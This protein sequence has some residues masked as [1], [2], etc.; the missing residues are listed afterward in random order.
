MT[1]PS[2]A[3]GAPVRE[4]LRARDQQPGEHEAGEDPVGHLLER[5]DQRRQLR[6][7][8]VRGEVVV[9]EALGDLVQPM[10]QARRGSRRSPSRSGRAAA[11]TCR[12]RARSTAISLPN[13]R[14]VSSGVY[15]GSSAR[16]T[17]SRLNSALAS[18]VI[19]AGR[20]SPCW[21][22]RS[23]TSNRMLSRLHLGRGELHV[24]R[25]ERGDLPRVAGA[26]EVVRRLALLDERRGHL[27][28][29]VVAKRHEEPRGRVAHG[30]ATA[31]P[32][33]RSRSARAG[34]PRPRARGSAAACASTS[35]C[36][37]GVAASRGSSRRSPPPPR[38][39]SS[40]SACPAARR[41]RCPDADRRGRSRRCVIPFRYARVSSSATGVK[42]CSRR[43]SGDT[44]S[45]FT[46]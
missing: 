2:G 1:K 33:C 26:V 15:D 18:S 34:R 20:R 19:S 42:S 43:A 3:E 36:A 16:V 14:I 21:N 8:H 5:D 10:R 17:P 9:R 11:A 40:G 24:A 32:S 25:D 44:S 35:S 13:S 41:T 31:A 22:E 37:S 29:A 12:A 4:E 27:V 23:I 45:T 46:P 28:A 38:R 39:G 30:G 7:V 6:H